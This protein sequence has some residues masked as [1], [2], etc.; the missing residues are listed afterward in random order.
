MQPSQPMR[1]G[2]ETA[3]SRRRFLHRLAA[4]GVMTLAGSELLGACGKDLTPPP[5][6]PP[7]QTP[8]AMSSTVTGRMTGAPMA[9]PT[10]EISLPPPRTKGSM[11][12]EEALAQRRSVRAYTD[13]PPSKEDIAQ[14]FWA[15]QGVTRSWGGRTAPSAGALYPLEIYAVTAEGAYHYLPAH[16]RAEVSL[17]ED[18]R[19]AL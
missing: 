1:H 14:L 5:T 4:A 18:V 16:H 3:L 17:Q 6:K 2:R 12:L 8:F 13:K 10:K 19:Q 11:S 7:Q 9:G 15:A